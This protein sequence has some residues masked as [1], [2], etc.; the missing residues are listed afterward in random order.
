MI[1]IHVAMPIV[2]VLSINTRPKLST[3]RKTKRFARMVAVAI[4]YTVVLAEDIV[5]SWMYSGR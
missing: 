2:P 3:N 5:K 1:V 4:M